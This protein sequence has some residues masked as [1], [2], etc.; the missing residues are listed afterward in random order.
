MA[1]EELKAEQGK[2]DLMDADLRSARALLLQSDDEAGRIGAARRALFARET[3]AQ[4]KSVLSPALWISLAAEM[5]G[6]AVEISSVGS[7]WARNLR[8]RLGLGQTLGFLAVTL[9]LLALI[10]PV[11]WAAR[12]MQQRDSAASSPSRLR[13]ALA[14]LWVIVV[15]GGT[16]LALLGAFAYAL[17]AFDI[18]DPRLQGV[19]DA[20]LNGL[21]LIALTNAFGRALLAPAEPSWRVCGLG[22]RAAKFTFR[23]VMIAAAI[24]AVEQ[25]LEA[26]AEMTS[27]LN[28]SI[29]S[30][31]TGAAVIALAGASRLRRLVDPRVAPPSGRD[32]WAPARTLAWA[33]LALMF[34]AALAGYI[35]L[36]AF[37]VNQ[38]LIVFLVGSALYIADALVQESAET[39]LKPEEAVGFGLMTIIGLRRETLEQLV[40][41]AQGF[42]R[43][44]AWA[45]ALLV[46][47]GPLGLP[48]RDILSTLRAVYFGY[49]IGGVT[50]SL[51][52]LITAMIVLA[53]SMLATRAAQNWLSE[54]YLP[55]TRLDAAVSNSIRIIAGYIGVVAALLLAGSS[56]GL[57]WRQFAIIAGA[58]SVGI[59]F[60][61]QGIVN[62]FVSGLILLWERSVR[63]GDWVAVGNEQ[64]FVRRINARATEIETFDRATLIVPNSTFVTG[65]V[66]NWMHNDRVGRI[67][68][69]LNVDFGA[70]PERVRE[71][72]IA[73]AKAQETVLAI[74]A[75]LALFSEF[76]DWALKFQLICFVDDA[77][78]ADRVRSEMNFDLLQRLREAGVRLALPYPRPT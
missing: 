78:I 44:A 69:A 77:L 71:L 20:L 7:D 51:S 15:F 38:G 16:P 35:A 10:F 76:G 70:D 41:I 58:L 21:R 55:R 56:L 26:A 64:G 33:F 32:P 66:K 18:S 68:I 9:A 42:A 52:S 49:T 59:G 47:F 11:R 19:L 30:R 24:W 22:D 73:V 46:A 54:R 23:F 37:L 13:R 67:I 1:T 61:L 39:F 28:I 57:D 53:V 17:D 65:N 2:H 62:N 27:S 72:M 74:P 4:S 5:P 60:G 48:S 25:L 63:V 43:F 34:G 14:A 50:I 6:D 3:F 75:P 40:V 45:A 36:A 31:A 29:A 12:R 8:Q